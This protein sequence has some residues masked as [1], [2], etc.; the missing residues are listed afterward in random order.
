[1]LSLVCGF[2]GDISLSSIYDLMPHKKG[3]HYFDAA[4]VQKNQQN[5]I[6]FRFKVNYE[7]IKKGKF[8][9]NEQKCDKNQQNCRV[10]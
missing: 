4:K 1:M 2:H 7:L 9:H 10:Y 5:T 6:F 8:V 3:R